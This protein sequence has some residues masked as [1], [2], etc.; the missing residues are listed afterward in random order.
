M[1]GR[2]IF[3]RIFPNMPEKV[4]VQL[5]PTKFSPTKIIMTFFWCDLKK[6]LHVFF[7]KPWVPFLES[8]NFWWHFYP[9]FQQIKPSGGA[10]ASTAPT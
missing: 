4:F 5:L 10:L 1:V 6:G 3:S 8:S 9:D 7:C 2:R